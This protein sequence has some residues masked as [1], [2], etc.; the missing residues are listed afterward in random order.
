MASRFRVLMVLSSATK[1]TTTGAPTGW[2]LPEFAHPY[3]VLSEIADVTVVSPK[4]GFSQVDPGS[5]KN[6]ATTDS[7][8][9]S[10]LKDNESVW[11]NTGKISDY[12]GRGKEFDVI[13]HPGG[14]APLF[15]LAEDND[16]KTL[17][18]EVYEAGK[19]VAAICH[20]VIVLKDVKLSN[21][22]YL[23]ADAPV[24][25]FSNEEE[26]KVGLT[27]A[28]PVLVETELVKMGG[29]F[30]KSDAPFKAHVT[31]AHNGRLIT[32]QNPASAP[33]F[34]EAIKQSL[35]KA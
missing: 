33:E 10:F 27:D 18:S 34:A 26:D 25:G 12:I 31:V 23:V 3:K 32:G 19:I 14:H 15:D 20:G 16:L 11:S 7:L 22:Q 21:G 17:I 30:E 4:G 6:T 29:R 5:V 28:C 13:C 35:L 9:H 1:F 8:S 24:T 2:Y